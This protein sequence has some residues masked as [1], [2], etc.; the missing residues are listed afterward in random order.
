MLV[1]YVILLRS[2]RIEPNSSNCDV[3]TANSQGSCGQAINGMPWLMLGDTGGRGV[4]P[5]PPVNSFGEGCKGCENTFLVLTA[6]KFCSYFRQYLVQC[7]RSF[8]HHANRA[9][10]LAGGRQGFCLIRVLPHMPTT[11]VFHDS[12]TEL[13]AVSATLPSCPIWSLTRSGRSCC[14]L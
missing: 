9:S 10:H 12:V 2:R 5:H 3:N 13:P 6:G 7:S 8:S 1:R 11:T 4:R 14:R